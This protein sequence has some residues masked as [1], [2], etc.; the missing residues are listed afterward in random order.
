MIQ[1]IK[2]NQQDISRVRNVQAKE[3]PAP[4]TPEQEQ[5]IKSVDTV[6]LG[7]NQSPSILYAR[8]KGKELKASD[9]DALKA[10]ADKTFEGLR[11]LVRQMLLKQ[12]EAA[13]KQ[14]L[15]SIELTPTEEAGLS[16]SEDGEF[17]VKA[18][19]NRIVSFAISVSDNDP[20]K[21]AELKEAIDKGFA[22]AEKTFGGKLPDICYQT[23][24]EI[25]KKLDKWSDGEKA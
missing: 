6:E 2:S 8:P 4:L 21:L 10:Q 23:H 7:T 20:A 25:M 19:S 24:D 9:I 15:E 13:G 14:K 18:V 17:G 1:E 11:N 5:T 3:K 16:I 12:R 22:A